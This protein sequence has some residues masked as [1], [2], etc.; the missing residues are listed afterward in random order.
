M[1]PLNAC[2]LAPSKYD[3]VPLGWGALLLTLPAILSSLFLLFCVPPLCLDRSALP[4]VSYQHPRAITLMDKRRV[5]LFPYSLGPCRVPKTKSSSSQA[6]FHFCF[7]WSLNSCPIPPCLG[8][9]A[10]K[11]G[12]SLQALPRLQLNPSQLLR[13]PSSVPMVTVSL[14]QGVKRIRS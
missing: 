7:L 8:R 11:P 4:A 1:H 2:L 9:P 5:T 13:L 14:G 3:A 10:F 6:T 12:A